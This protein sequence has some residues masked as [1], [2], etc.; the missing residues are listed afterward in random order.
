MSVHS[1]TDA[2]IC[3]LENTILLL[4]IEEQKMKPKCLN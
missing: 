3:T 1:T 2:H 4:D